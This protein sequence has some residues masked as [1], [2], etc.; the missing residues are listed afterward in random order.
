M[1]IGALALILIH[2]ITNQKRVHSMNFNR[3]THRWNRSVQ[4]YIGMLFQFPDKSNSGFII[5]TADIRLVDMITSPEMKLNR[6]M[7]ADDGQQ[8]RTVNIPTCKI[9]GKSH[10]DSIAGFY[11]RL[12]TKEIFRHAMIDKI[13]WQLTMFVFIQYLSCYRK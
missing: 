12:F 2:I 11:Y 6:R 7:P 10:A 9:A 5:R 1:V 13:R 4:Y 3:E 8:Y